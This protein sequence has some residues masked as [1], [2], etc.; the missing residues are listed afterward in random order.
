[1]ADHF[2][3]HGLGSMLLARLVETARLAGIGELCASVL[4]E[5]A[6]ML[7]VF[8]GAGLPYAEEHID[9][10]IELAPEIGPRCV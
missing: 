5:N 4:A 3:H 10:V 7:A 2:Q 6:T 8:H 1:M 9:D